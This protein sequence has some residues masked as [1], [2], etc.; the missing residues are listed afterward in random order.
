MIPPVSSRTPEGLPNKCPLC[1]N[2]LRIE[3]SNPP[4]DAP[5]PSCGH[6]LWFS[7]KKPK[8][9][10]AWKG[11]FHLVGLLVSAAALGICW[12]I[13][14]SELGWVEYLVLGILAILLFGRRL[15]DVGH[16]LGRALVE[17]RFR[18]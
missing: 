9:W 1:G 3:P 18:K 5:C 2:E 15:P 12:I 10:L 16:Y 11:E 7:G 13:F 4:G 17:K 6:L 8:R 14:G